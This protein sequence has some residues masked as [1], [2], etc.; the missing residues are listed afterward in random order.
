MKN[1]I[2]HGA[3]AFL[4]DKNGRTALFYLIESNIDNRKEVARLLIENKCPID[5]LDNES[6]TCLIEAV[7]LDKIGNSIFILKK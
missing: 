4:Q 6:N 3:H 7:K 5:L 2:K 1:L